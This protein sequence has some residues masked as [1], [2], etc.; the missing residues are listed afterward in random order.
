M[1][2]TLDIPADLAQ[3]LREKASEQ[4]VDLNHLVVEACRSFLDQSRKPKRP[5]AKKFPFPIF[6]GGHPAKP[7]EELTPEKVSEI[8]WGSGE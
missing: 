1:R 3:R 5:K 2:V 6:K 7:G 4:G 8:L